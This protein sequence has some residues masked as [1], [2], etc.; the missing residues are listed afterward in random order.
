MIRIS[1]ERRK[2]FL[3]LLVLRNSITLVFLFLMTGYCQYALNG[4]SACAQ[5]E[6][7][8]VICH[9]KLCHGVFTT[10]VMDNIDHKP[11]SNTA[12]RS[13]HETGIFLSQHPTDE[14]Q[15][16]S[17]MLSFLAFITF[18]LCLK[19]MSSVMFAMVFS[20][21]NFLHEFSLTSTLTTHIPLTLNQTLII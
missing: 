5:F 17:R 12:Q 20:M 1:A 8:S 6:R 3:V 4:E 10:S 11:S 21:L 2:E 13:L 14:N 16:A 18:S 9:S 15:E 19:S 7:Q